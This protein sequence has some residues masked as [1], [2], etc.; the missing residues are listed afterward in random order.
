MSTNFTYGLILAIT[1]IA[2]TLVGYF[3]GYQTEKIMDGRWFGFLPL[4]A[5]IVIIVLGIRAVREE[6]KDKS[7]SY[8]RGVGAGTMVALYA[9]LFG[10][11]YTFIHFSFINPEFPDYLVSASRP[12]WAAAGMSESQMEAAEQGTRIFTK[13]LIQSIFSLILSPI[14]GCV[15]SLLASIFLKRAPAEPAAVAA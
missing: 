14:I 3:L 12:Q 1:N 13:P 8:G 15:V 5:M 11:I 7:L 6:S 9:G 10:A 4:V 2:L